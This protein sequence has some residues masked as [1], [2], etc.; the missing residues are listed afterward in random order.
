MEKEY[1]I[2]RSLLLS[3]K[4]LGVLFDAL[5]RVMNASGTGGPSHKEIHG[6]NK[7]ALLKCVL[8]IQS[9][10]VGKGMAR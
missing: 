7:E 5:E 3:S 4:D 8:S 2:I 10:E 6:L 1:D 9:H